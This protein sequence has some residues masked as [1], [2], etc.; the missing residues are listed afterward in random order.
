MDYQFPGF[1]P[2]LNEEYEWC[3]KFVWDEYCQPHR[4]YHT[5]HHIHNMFAIARDLGEELTV[6]QRVAILYHDIVYI[7]GSNDNER[8]S[9]LLLK[10]HI[11]QNPT[12]FKEAFPNA[13]IE[14]ISA[15]IMDTKDHNPSQYRES[16]LVL[17][18]DMS[19]LATNQFDYYQYTLDIRKE[20]ADFD[21]ERMN[22]GRAVFLQGILLQ[23][24]IFFTDVCK[25]RF[26]QAARDNIKWEL[27]EL[28]KL[29]EVSK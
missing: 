1:I 8:L 21:G 9:V 28:N 11:A 2:A 16:K 7:P 22:V 10:T 26:E 4:F 18:L 12:Q 6:N 27:D 17:D 5:W 20:Y 14:T 15:I 19:I 3:V 29:I 24:N 25:A 13:N 23:P